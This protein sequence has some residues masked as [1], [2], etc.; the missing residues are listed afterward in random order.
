[1]LSRLVLPTLTAL[2]LAAAPAFGDTAVTTPVDAAAFAGDTVATT[3]FSAS[4]T[5]T[6]EST[7]DLRCA[8]RYNGAWHYDYPLTGGN[9]IP[10]T[11]G[12]WTASSLVVPFNAN[13][14]RLLALPGGAPLP[15]GAT[16]PLPNYSGPRLRFA[17]TTHNAIT[18][19]SNTGNLYDF[20]ADLGGTAATAFIDSIGSYGIDDT[21]LLG[22]EPTDDTQ[23]FGGANYIRQFDPQSP[24]TSGSGTVF[25]L[26][27]DGIN[28]W[29]AA[30]WKNAGGNS[31]PFYNWANTPV[32]SADASIAADTSLVVAEH[33]TLRQCTAVDPTYYPLAGFTCQNSLVDPG[34][35]IDVTTTVSPTGARIRRDW[36]L[37]STDG[38]AHTVHL[39]LR[40]DIAGNNV[41]AREWRLPGGAYA[42][43]V[44]GDIVTAA[45]PATGPF[46]V[47][48][49][50]PAAPDP[51]PTEGLGSLTF[52]TIPAEL[53]FTGTRVLTATYNLAVP[54]TGARWL[55]FAFGTEDNQ[56]AIDADAAAAE[57]AI[58]PALAI[59]APADGATTSAAT[60]LV[61]G[62]ASDPTGLTGLTVAG[63]DVPVAGDGTWS[64]TVALAD[65]AN[66]ITAVATNALGATATAQRSVTRSAGG[67]P[68]SPP[69]S[70]NYGSPVL[71]KRGKAALKKRLLRLGYRV[72]CPGTGP[73]CKVQI[74]LTAKAKPKKRAKQLAKTTLV[75]AAGTTA[76]LSVKVKA[77]K[78]ALKRAKPTLTITLTRG[79]LTPHSVTKALRL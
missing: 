67:G 37:T 44:D 57:A 7:V 20:G 24:A 19:G 45:L 16:D 77:S 69:G 71:T 36:K 52:S 74:L 33:D 18:G 30:A 26:Q 14:C 1:M 39:V 68:G 22:P 79:T 13:P 75:V 76:D 12:T 3:T 10:V 27:V 41:I 65:G 42:A 21:Y 78:A 63:Q 35:G 43:H 62:T 72:G 70:S 2:S 64:A 61:T 5:A 54:A 17:V 55:S 66:Q 29:V 58:K 31:S 60:A 9:G 59:T 38:N 4:G 56:A 47:A 23:V 50:R 51:D 49:R 6:S 8:R 25:G 40:H 34:V 11:G 53:R 48:V 15:S 28:T 73:A 32:I 46:S